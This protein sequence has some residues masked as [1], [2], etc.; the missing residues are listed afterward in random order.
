MFSNLSHDHLDY[1]GTMA[2]YLDAKQML[3]D[4]R[5][6]GTAKA[7]AAVVNGE[8]DVAD[9]FAAAATRA[10]RPVLVCSGV[11]LGRARHARVRVE[12]LEPKPEGLDLE[13]AA[14][15]RFDRAAASGQPEP[16]ARV[17]V[18][19]PLLGR[20]NAENAAL[21]FGASLVLGIARDAIVRGPGP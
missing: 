14:I 9:E 2:A 1:H 18:R 21:A 10:G 5:N 20:F 3:F 12:R 16:T 6:G 8:S 13:F 19:L 4:G 7:G 11:P 15:D 17:R